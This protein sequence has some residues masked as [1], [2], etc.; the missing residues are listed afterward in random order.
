ME[1]AI[2]VVGRGNFAGGSFFEEQQYLMRAG[3]HGAAALTE[4]TNQGKSENVLIKANG[5]SQIAHVQRGF[6]DAI[7]CWAHRSLRRMQLTHDH[8]RF[9]R[10][11]WMLMP[12]RKRAAAEQHFGGPLA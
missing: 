2:S 4:V 1:F 3:M 11:A 5:M 9:P 8:N 6:Q 7:G 10:A 12:R